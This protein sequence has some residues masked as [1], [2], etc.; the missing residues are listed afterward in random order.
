MA[1]DISLETFKN[2]KKKTTVIMYAVIGLIV[3]ALGGVIASTGGGPGLIAGGLVIFGGCVMLIK[4]HG[5]LVDPRN[6]R[7]CDLRD[8]V[9]YRNME[10]PA[11]YL[12]G[13]AGVDT[14]IDIDE[15]TALM[16]VLYDGYGG[17]YLKSN[18]AATSIGDNFD[19]W[20]IPGNARATLTTQLTS[21]TPTNSANRLY[22]MNKGENRIIVK[23]KSKADKP[24]ISPLPSSP[25]PFVSLCDD[26]TTTA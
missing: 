11:S 22:V 9:R 2:N 25:V 14:D 4:A 16:K 10:I 12:N 15:K 20:Y 18:T 3:I 21:A 24:T 19:V 5:E 17:A 6:E 26:Q 8:V 23:D 13:D 1:N 7:R